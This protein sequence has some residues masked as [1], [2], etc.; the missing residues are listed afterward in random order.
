MKASEI[1]ALKAKIKA[2]C[3]RRN[4]YGSLTSYAASN[5]DFSVAPTDG[6]VMLEE[7]GK[8]TIDI[9]LAV[10]DVGDLHFVKKDEIVPASFTTDLSAYVDKLATEPSTSTTSSCRGACTGLCLGTCHSACDGCSSTCNGCSSCTG[11]SKNS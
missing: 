2:E 4:G 11:A 3:A 9:L 5:Y 10:K 8:K 6:Q 1:T 7:H